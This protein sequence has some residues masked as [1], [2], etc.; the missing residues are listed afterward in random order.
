MS[1]SEFQNFLTVEEKNQLEIWTRKECQE[2]LF[3]SI[4]DNQSIN[5]SIFD[6]KI[7]FKKKFIIY[8]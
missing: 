2:I 7:Q 3:D 4:K 5:T 1:D 6:D 8:Y